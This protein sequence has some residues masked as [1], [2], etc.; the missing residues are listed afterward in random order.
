[1]GRPITR[2]C[3]QSNLKLQVWKRFD[4]RRDLTPKYERTTAK[5]NK[6]A[7]TS[8]LQMITSVS[9]FYGTTYVAWTRS[10]NDI[11][12]ISWSFLNKIISGLKKPEPI[13]RSREEDPIEG[14]DNDMDNIG[15]RELSNADDV[16]A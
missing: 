6:V 3:G 5:G 15:E 11:L 4:Q 13:M 7:G 9:K 16:K 8:T 12:Q 1:M 14:S 10:F 2:S